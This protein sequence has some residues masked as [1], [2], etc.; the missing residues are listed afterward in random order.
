MRFIT[1]I[2]SAISSVVLYIAMAF[3]VVISYTY[4]MLG[5]ALEKITSLVSHYLDDQLDVFDEA[6]N[7]SRHK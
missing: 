2:C 6:L 5:M 1:L 7:G 4:E 3:M